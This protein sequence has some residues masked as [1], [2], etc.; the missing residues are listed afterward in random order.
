M[1]DGTV[2][3]S[4]SG[5]RI[6]AQLIDTGSGFQLWAENFDRTEEN[7]FG[8]PAEIA[9][10]VVATLDPQNTE[11]LRGLGGNPE[12]HKLYLQGKHIADNRRDEA[13]LREAM[14]IL[15]AAVSIDTAFWPPHLGIA[16]VWIMLA[17]NGYVSA[18]IG[19]AQ[20]REIAEQVVRRDENV[21]EAHG[22][23]G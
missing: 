3:V 18:E 17:D 20:A 2:R 15:E 6:A 16:E 11:L 23:L 4:D 21:A 19:Y 9:R 14:Q 13:G 22:L 12:A 8:V 5:I 1:L 10:A 7:V